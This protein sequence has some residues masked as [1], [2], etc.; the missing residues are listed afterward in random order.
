MNNTAKNRLAL[1]AENAQV[2]K[3]EFAWD[4]T[5]IKMLAALLYAEEDKRIDC[6]AI[7]QCHDLIKRNTKLFSDFRGNTAVYMAALLS[8]TDNPQEVFEK[9]NAAFDL[10]VK[11]LLK[12]N[13]IGHLDLL[14]LAAYQ[15][16]T[17]VDSS[18]Y[19]D[20]VT[21]TKNFYDGMKA[22]HSIITG[23]D[24]YIYTVMLALTDLDA[25]A[26]VERIERLQVLL[27]ENGFR[28]MNSIQALAQTLVIAESDEGVIDRLLAL[29]E[30]FRSQKIKL[31][32]S[33]TL[34]V[35]G[36]LALLP[37]EV[38][39]IVS[40]IAE[41]RDYL[42]AQKG[43]GA[44]SVSSEEILMLATSILVGDYAQNDVNGVFK[45]TILTAINSLIY[46]NHVALLI[47]I[48]ATIL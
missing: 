18:E 20:V 25:D 43:F 23:E 32:R 15:I 1:F 40:D 35:L 36:I 9:V 4:E 38:D 30:A 45:A 19:T 8:L 12:G 5:S 22:R 29:R 11:I 26:G 6:E 47:I 48:I 21:R 10:L 46:A 42:K 39:S 44:L 17:T 2:I 31:D 3:K 34:P 13:I 33:Q 16:A 28:D 7:R 24:D 41:A 37:V 14:V 27:K